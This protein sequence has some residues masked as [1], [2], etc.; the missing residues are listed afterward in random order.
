MILLKLRRRTF[1]S[2]SILRNPIEQCAKRT[3]VPILFEAQGVV[4]VASFVKNQLRIPPP[5]KAVVVCTRESAKRSSIVTHFL[6]RGGY[7][8][9]SCELPS[10]EPF[11]FHV[12]Q[13]VEAAKLTGSSFVVAFGEGSVISI[14]KAAAALLGNP[15]EGKLIDYATDLGG[16]RQF[17]KA[18]VPLVV[19]PSCPSGNELSRSSPILFQGKRLGTI[20]SHPDS[21]QGVIADPSLSLSLEAPAALTTTYAAFLHCV[22]GFLRPDSDLALRALAFEGAQ[23][24]ALTLP[25]LMRSPASVAAHAQASIASL[26]AS[27]LM[28]AGPL[29]PARGLALS[30]ASQ[31]SVPYSTALTCV[32]PEAVAA[33]LAKTLER[34]DELHDGFD[35]GVEDE[36]EGAMV[37]ESSP[38]EVSSKA[39]RNQVRSE[40]KVFGDAEGL[41]EALA[42]HKAVLG[43]LNDPAVQQ[44]LQPYAEAAVRDAE[45]TKASMSMRLEEDDPST[46]ALSRFSRLAHVLAQTIER[47]S[48]PSQNASSGLEDLGKDWKM[49][50]N[51]ANPEKDID[52]FHHSLM[53]LRDNWASFGAKGPTLASYKDFTIADFEAIADAA[54]VETNVM[55]AVTPLS[56]SDL[57]D[58]LKRS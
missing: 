43:D 58:I 1:S 45:R 25:A 7:S 2:S 39:V 9:L 49:I 17:K 26:I 28:H 44:L 55:N 51:S 32:G 36:E 46:I 15:H 13:V 34:Y 6:R 56:K 52:Q 23:R 42:D 50:G 21:L 27:A 29:G 31:Y 12:D 53:F 19:V 57:I 48:S 16:K 54:E 47:M 35:E 4:K 10:N 40:A 41:D 24:A 5:Q 30:L 18:S 11:S 37:L 14:A 8:P 38:S 20:S 22:E 3:R 33:S